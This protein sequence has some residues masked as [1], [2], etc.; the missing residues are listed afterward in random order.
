MNVSKRKS[1]VWCPRREVR[2]EQPSQP[3]RS[4]DL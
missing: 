4:G 1:W 2:C 3:P